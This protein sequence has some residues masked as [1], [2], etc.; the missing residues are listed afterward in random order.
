MSIKIESAVFAKIERQILGVELKMLIGGE[1]VTAYIGEFC[2]LL[3]SARVTRLYGKSCEDVELLKR[4]VCVT[5]KLRKSDP[6]EHLVSVTDDTQI[7]RIAQYLVN[8]ANC[9]EGLH[10]EP[11]K[12]I[13]RT[14]W[15]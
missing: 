11:G 9:K 2:P 14:V 3:S 7:R 10:F 4:S 12:A 15:C 8:A 1:K 5:V 6:P 13:P